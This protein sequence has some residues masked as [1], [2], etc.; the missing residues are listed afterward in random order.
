MASSLGP[1]EGRVSHINTQHP[2]H[3]ANTTEATQLAI[4]TEFSLDV[5]QIL[6]ARETYKKGDYVVYKLMLDNLQIHAEFYPQGMPKSKPNYCAFF[7][8]I[9]NVKIEDKRKLSC[10]IGSVYEL[11]DESFNPVNIWC[12]CLVTALLFVC[13][14]KSGLL[15]VL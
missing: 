5:E 12:V 11:F 1:R 7:I 15:S 3:K 14:F 4:E 2:S 10:R 9:P 8:T 13:R 6:L